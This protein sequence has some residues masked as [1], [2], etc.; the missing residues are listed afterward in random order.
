MPISVLK[1][2]LPFYGDKTNFMMRGGLRPFNLSGGSYLNFVKASVADRNFLAFHK[3]WK[4]KIDSLNNAQRGTQ[5]EVT[6]ALAR[7]VNLRASK[8]D[9]F[10]DLWHITWEAKTYKKDVDET[11]AGDLEDAYDLAARVATQTPFP[12]HPILPPNIPWQRLTWDRIVEAPAGPNYVVFSDMHMMDHSS[13]FSL[14]NY[15]K[16]HNLDLYLEVLTHYA[17]QPGWC[18]VENGDVEECIIYEVDAGDAQVRKSLSKPARKYPITQTDADWDAFMAVRYTKREATLGRLFISFRPYYDLIRDRFIAEDRYVRL[19]G[20]HDTY[21][22]TERERVLRNMIEDELGVAVADV[23]TVSQGGQ[24]SHLILHGH[25]FD[26]VSIQ[27]G[28][29]PYALSLGEVFSETVSWIYEGPDRFWPDRDCRAWLAGGSIGNILAREEESGYSHDTIWNLLNAGGDTARD[30]IKAD[31]RGF[32]EALLE[33]EIAWEY[34]EN[35]DPWYA[36]ALEVATGDEWFKLR[37]LNERALC[38]GYFD[39]YRHHSGQSVRQAKAN[40]PKLVLGHTHEPRCNAVDPNHGERSWY[41]NS[42]SAGRF[43]NLIW[44]V[45]ITPSGDRI[46]SWSRVDGR[47]RK[48]IWRDESAEFPMPVP[49]GEPKTIHSSNLVLDHYEYP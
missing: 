25:Q 7:R 9:I 46:V 39:R 44:A 26:T 27:S 19:T 4:V 24:I 41:L 23:A 13:D 34:F 38:D 12:N 45:E 1:D 33:H 47:L 10:D 29:V 8:T 11:I 6:K 35:K 15:F 32:V 20:N 14:P 30:K 3:D 36:L 18:L 37:H 42:G 2:C 22:N 17:D 49:W 31:T 21:S 5:G 43:E 28:A 16:D 40:I 48:T